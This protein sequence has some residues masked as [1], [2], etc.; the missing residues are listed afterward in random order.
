MCL[1]LN[2][3]GN[4]DPARA[5]AFVRALHDEL[6]CDPA[7]P[8]Q[9]K[10]FFGSITTLRPD[11]MGGDELAHIGA[12]LGLDPALLED[13]RVV[14]LRHTLMNPWLLDEAN[15]VN[16]IDLYCDYLAGLVRAEVA[17]GGRTIAAA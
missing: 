16:Y 3:A 14:I 11:A 9:L 2:P 12:C 5:N 1:A 6:R 8:L 7:R 17:A 10:E 15:G 13:E 4:R